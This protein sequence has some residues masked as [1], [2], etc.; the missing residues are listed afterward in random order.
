MESEE[1]KQESH[2]DER[3]PLQ[4]IAATPLSVVQL[5]HRLEELV[6]YSLECESGQM[7]EDFSFVD[8]YK[9]L[10]ELRKVIDTFSKEQQDLLREITKAAGEESQEIPF[11]KEDRAVLSKIQELQGVCETAK[12]RLYQTMQENPDVEKQLQ[13]K[14]QE[15]GSTKQRKKVRRRGKFRRLGG[16]KDWMPT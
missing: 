7:R 8:I 13:E 4:E 9:Q 1:E 15:A 10:L 3:P 11:S 6:K 5:V 14:V 16:K 2:E 12:D